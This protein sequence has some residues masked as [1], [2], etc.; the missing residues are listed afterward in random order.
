[1]IAIDTRESLKP[2]KVKTDGGKKRKRLTVNKNPRG[3]VTG[4]YM[5]FVIKMLNEMDKF[6]EMKGFYTVMDNA[7]IHTSQD[8]R[9]MIE[10][11]GYRVIYLPP[12]SPE[13]NPNEN[14]WAVLKG[15]VK[16]SVFQEVKDLKTRITE[17]S[18]SIKRNTLQNISQHSINNFDKCLNK[19]KKT[20]F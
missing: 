9:T 17:A 8:I 10:S 1:M 7:P 19:K 3:T 12:Y 13:L 5:K 16:R 4:H 15:A 6:S 14:F 20:F 18:Q 2:K 11:R